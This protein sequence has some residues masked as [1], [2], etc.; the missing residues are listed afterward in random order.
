MKVTVDI[1]CTPQEARQFFGLPDVQ[2]MQKAFM[3]EIQKRMM[4]EVER[5]SPEGLMKTWLSLAPQNVDWF[6]DFFSG[7]QQGAGKK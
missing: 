1:E 5:F 2:P 3:D 6:K 7:A 4:T